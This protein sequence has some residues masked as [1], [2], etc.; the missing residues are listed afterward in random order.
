MDWQRIVP[1]RERTVS[2]PPR[3]PGLFVSVRLLYMTSGRLLTGICGRDSVLGELFFFGRSLSIEV[4]HT[5]EK[6][7]RHRWQA[8]A[9]TLEVK[10]RTE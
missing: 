8:A 10:R 2:A 9:V 7:A 3:S 1:E 6:T 5:F 4:R